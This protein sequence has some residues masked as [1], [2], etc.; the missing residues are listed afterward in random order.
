MIGHKHRQRH[1]DYEPEV[2][3]YKRPFVSHEIGQWVSFPD[4]YSWFD[5]EKY[6]GPLKAHYIGMLKKKFEKYHPAELGPKFAR[7]SGALQV[8]CYKTEIEAMFRS[9]SM[10]GFHLNG[11]MDY[12][13]EGVALIGILDVM[14]DSKNLITPEEFRRFLFGYRPAVENGGGRRRVCR[15][16]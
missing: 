3:P 16:Q 11:L 10:D 9:P 7:A 8:L 4:F 1:F 6:T 14:G 5:E 13:G 12:P 2:G 15:R